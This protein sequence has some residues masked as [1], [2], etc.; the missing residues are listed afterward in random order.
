MDKTKNHFILRELW[1]LAWN[2]SVQRSK[3]YK[4]KITDK[5]KLEFRWSLI[6]FIEKKIVPKYKNQ[7]S[8]EEHNKNIAQVI[9]VA[10]NF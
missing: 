2:A 9:K 6:K 10:N 3:I 4:P 7:V 5:S 1:I 8:E